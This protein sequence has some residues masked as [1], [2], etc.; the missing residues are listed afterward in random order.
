MTPNEGQNI[1]GKCIVGPGGHHH[2]WDEFKHWLK[3]VIRFVVP[4]ACSAALVWWL[5]SKVDFHDVLKVLNDHVQYGWLAGVVVFTVLSYMI[6]AYRWGLQLSGVGINVPYHTLCVSIFGAYGLNLIFYG[7]GEAWRCIFIAR[8]SCTSLSKVVGTDIGDRSSDAVCVIGLLFLTLIFAKSDL[9]A[10]LMHYE[11]GRDIDHLIDNWRFWTWIV[12]GFSAIVWLYHALRNYR[13]MKKV[14]G[15]VHEIWDGFKVI[16]TMP[17]RWLYLWLTCAIWL[18]YYLQNYICFPGFPFTHELMTEH[19][20]FGL[21]PGLVACLFVSMSM[22]VPSSGGL[23]PWNIAMIFALS[24]YG[25]PR[26]EGTAFAMILWSAQA[27]TNV[28]VGIFAMCYIAITRKRANNKKL[29][30]NKEGESVTN[31]IAND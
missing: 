31:P 15:S 12:V 20:N 26:T 2:V 25:I 29:I 27:L 30:V 19:Y 18:C 28:G 14:H 22:A 16:F 10:F 11:V 3:P 5:F 21:T 13:F 1:N 9:N 23:G 4:I 6:R 8:R 17:H 24:L 7:A